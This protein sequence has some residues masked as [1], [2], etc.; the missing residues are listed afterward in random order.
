MVHCDGCDHL[1]IVVTMFTNHDR[2][3]ETVPRHQPNRP[4]GGGQ[5]ALAAAEYFDLHGEPKR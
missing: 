4:S 2:D 1:I 5:H 3:A